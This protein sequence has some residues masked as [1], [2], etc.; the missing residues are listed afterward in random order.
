MAPGGTGECHR[1]P[2]RREST[3]EGKARRA[4][5][6]STIGERRRL[7]V[8]GH[9]LVRRVLAQVAPVVTPD[10]I[11][12]WHRELVARKWT[13]RVGR[14]CPVGLQAHLRVLVIRMAA[15]NPTWG[16]TR[17]QGA[18]KTWA[19]ALAAPRSRR[20]LRAKGIPPAPP[21]PMTWRTF[22]QAHW[23]VRWRQTSSRPKCGPFAAW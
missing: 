19:I 18:S 12:R 4:A 14:G 21:R 23:P 20:T 10:T 1:V 15:N 5:C 6:A 8:L 17:I 22:V 16:Y 2:A 11:L 13:Y 9:R 3:I 7:A